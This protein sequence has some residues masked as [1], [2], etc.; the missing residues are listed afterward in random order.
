MEKRIANTQKP[1]EARASKSLAMKSKC[2]GTE[3]KD[4][5]TH[6]YKPSFPKNWDLRTELVEVGEQVPESRHLAAH[7]RGSAS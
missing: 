1:I 7:L 2:L 4:L 5:E 6:I 3:A